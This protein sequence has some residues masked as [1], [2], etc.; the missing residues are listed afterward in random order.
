MIEIL[1]TDK[2]FEDSPDVGT[3]D[4]ICSRCLKS[5]KEDDI[6]IRCW[7]TNKIG[8]VDKYS[9][10]YCFC[11]SCQEKCGIYTFKNENN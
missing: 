9:L 3:N 5:I 7:T 1:Q 6:P 8:K 4:C 2:A 10:E 11:E